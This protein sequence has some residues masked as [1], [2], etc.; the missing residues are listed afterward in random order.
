MDEALVKKVIEE[1]LKS[2]R[3]TEQTKAGCKDGLDR[4]LV[5]GDVDDVPQS[6]AE[7]HALFSIEDYAHDGN[8]HWYQKLLITK[9]TLTQLSD[10]AQ[11]RDG[12]PEA[13]AVIMGLLNGVEVCM[14]ENALPHRKYAGRSSSRIYEVIENN[15][16][17]IQTFGVKVL[18]KARPAQPEKARPPKYQAPPVQVPKGSAHPNGER[19]ITEAVA[20]ALTG[21][22]EQSVCVAKDAIITPLAW[23]IFNQHGVHVIR[24]TGR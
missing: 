2:L 8:I 1:V 24:E 20:R 22:G 7:T 23:D 6:I 5:I 14:L 21:S 9:L 10:I 18:K 11:G 3:E 15:A 16:K 17:M 19:L 13:C 12:S 4:L